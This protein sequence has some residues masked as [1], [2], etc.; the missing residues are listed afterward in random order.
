ITQQLVKNA[1]V[2]GQ[3]S[4]SRKIKEVI[5]A[6]EIEQ[7]FSKNEILELYLNEIPYGS[8]AYGIE[9]A[10]ETYFDK[11]AKDLTLAESAY[12]AALPQAPTYYSPTGPHFDALQARQKAVLQAMRDQGYITEDQQQQALDEK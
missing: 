10:A 8:N 3:R 6:I 5:L 12:L 1:I 2:G 11:H 7:K 9:A 4:F